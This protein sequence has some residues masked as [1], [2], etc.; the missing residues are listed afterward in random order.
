[1]RPALCVL[2]AGVLSIRPCAVAAQQGSV[3]IFTAAQ[4]VT[5]SPDRTGGD[6]P[7]QP[8]FGASWLQPGARFGTFQIETRGS[9]RAD[10]LHVGRTYA[11]LR[12]LRYGGFAW[13]FEAGDAYFTRTLS[14]YSFV[15]LTAPAATFNGGSITGRGARASIQIVGGRATAWRNIFGSDPDTLAQWISLVR[16]SARVSERVE[17]L[18]RASRIRTSGL[19]E[20]TFSIA[21]SRQAGGGVRIALT[22]SI[23][24]IGDAAAVQYRR[25][26]ASVQE[27]DGSVLVGANV[28]LAR[29]WIQINASRLSPGDSP[30]M[31]DPLHD[32]E[33]VFSAGE[34]DLGSRGR[35]FGGWEAFRTNLSPHTAGTASDLPRNT[36]HRVFGGVRLQ[37]EIGRAHV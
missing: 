35:V 9:R 10:R 34:Y 13:T 37:I 12:D 30:L 21:D 33:T 1:M 20:F 29:G 5:G 4:G 11:A 16:G 18:G 28:H 32:R 31:N 23:D 24:L 25:R 6:H 3:Q 27:R 19:S 8:E 15:N 2:A 7:V 14:D 26:D 22:P 36:G 17:L